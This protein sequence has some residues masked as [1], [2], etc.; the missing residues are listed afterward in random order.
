MKRVAAILLTVAVLATACTSHRPAQPRPSSSGPSFHESPSGTSAAAGPGPHR[1]PQAAV[2]PEENVPSALTDPRAKGLPKPLVDPARIIDGGPPPDGIP[3][4]ADANFERA[5]TVNWLIGEEPVLSLTLGGETRAYPVQIMIFHEIA[6]DTVG[7]V[8]VAVTYCPLCNSAIAFDRRVAGR[9]VTFGTSGKLLYSNLVMY[10]RQTRS[11][12]PQLAGQAVAGV[13]TGTRLTAYPVQT[14]TWRD[15]L[16]ANPRSWVLSR[17]TGYDRVYGLNPYSG[18]DQPTSQPFDLDNA[19]DTRLPPKT[20]IVALTTG[21]PVAITLDALTSRRV[22]QLTQAGQ[23]IV[24]WALPGLRSALDTPDITSGRATAATGA[25]AAHWHGRLLHFTAHGNT[26]HTETGSHWTVLGRAV[27]GPAAG[28]HLQ[29]VPY[30]DTFWFAWA[31]Y[32]P[33]TH[34]LN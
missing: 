15:W 17:H 21:E 32:Q 16:A 2:S 11:L 14:V 22:V 26:F 29:P 34:I 28:D 5:D 6:N 31:A 27:S 3:A 33:H 18:Y 8:P 30:L 24:V 10:D 19:A 13:L 25:F 20:R 1:L 12:W 4:L 23:D 9:V 7:G